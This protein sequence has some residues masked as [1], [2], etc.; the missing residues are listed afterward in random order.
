MQYSQ[1]CLGFCVLLISHLAC[2]RLLLKIL[3]PNSIL[4][5]VTIAY[6]PL[7]SLPHLHHLLIFP[8]RLTPVQE[9][10]IQKSTQPSESTQTQLDKSI[11]KIPEKSTPVA[12]SLAQLKAASVKK[13]TDEKRILAA[14]SE[15]RVV[16]STKPKGLSGLRKM[17]L[18]LR[19]VMLTVADLNTPKARYIKA[20]WNDGLC[21]WN[22]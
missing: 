20:G 19:D 2:L 14:I 12:P 9:H 3:D 18:A 11:P 17:C 22:I 6:T 5:N 1:I 21:A 13:I 15:I 16:L 7:I 8:P 10:C 4:V